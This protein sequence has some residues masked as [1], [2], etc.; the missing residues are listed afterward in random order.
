[1]FLCFASVFSPL[2]IPFFPYEVTRSRHGVREQCR[3]GS[4]GERRRTINPRH[5]TRVRYEVRNDSMEPSFRDEDTIRRIPWR[6][7]GNAIAQ[8]FLK[9]SEI[10]AARVNGKY[11]LLD[12][13][14]RKG[15]PTYRYI[16][17]S[18]T[19][20]IL[21]ARRGSLCRSELVTGANTR[22]QE[23]RE[24]CAARLCRC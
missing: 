8:R 7:R 3:T 1:M 2:L 16:A 19:R 23:G 4:G 5:C 11:Q 24:P 18:G 9:L 6:G 21:R 12:I 10:I 20:C 14:K 13:R 17:D 22:L 15:G